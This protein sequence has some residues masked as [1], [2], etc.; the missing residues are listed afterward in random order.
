MGFQGPQ[1]L[2]RR[3]PFTSG[4]GKQ[5]IYKPLIINALPIFGPNKKTRAKYLVQKKKAP[6]RAVNNRVY[7]YNLLTFHFFHFV[8]KDWAE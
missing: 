2:Y 7:S 6:H 4:K 3:P 1:P 8:F 5:S